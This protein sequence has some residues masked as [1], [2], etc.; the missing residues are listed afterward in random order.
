MNSTTKQRLIK[1]FIYIVIG[2]T[3]AF[4]WNKMRNK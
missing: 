3:I 4:F 2:F 1:I